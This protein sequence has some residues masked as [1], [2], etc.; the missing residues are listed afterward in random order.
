MKEIIYTIQKNEELVPGIFE[1]VLF[2]DTS[3]LKTSGQFVNIRLPNFYLR[4]PF[5][6]SHY[7]ASNLTIIYQVVGEGT[8]SLSQ[9]STKHK[10]SCLI[11]ECRGFDVTNIPTKEVVVIGGGLGIAP[12]V[13]LTK[14]LDTK[15]IK[16][17]TVIGYKS[18]ESAFYYE[19]FKEPIIYCE[20]G[21]LGEK[22]LVSDA[23]IKYKFLELPYFCCGPIAMMKA[24]HFLNESEGQLL[25]EERMGCGFGIC[26]GCSIKTK[27][28]N[29]QVC[30]D[31]P[32]FYSKELEWNN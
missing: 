1:L 7:N 15:S 14:E 17:H 19:R 16:Y 12:L 27:K 30:K 11:S 18:K 24:I 9:L 10:L 21:T 3:L 25:L 13:Q 28:G 2:G 31:G 5:S 29:K 6:V 8:A 23:L 32:M 4:R 22:G 26:K 20:D